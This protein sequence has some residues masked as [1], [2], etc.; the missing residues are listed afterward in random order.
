MANERKHSATEIIIS[1]YKSNNYQ[2]RQK[3]RTD[4]EYRKNQSCVYSKRSHD[5]MEAGRR[6][7][8]KGL[9]E[10]AP[11]FLLNH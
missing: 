4:S 11:P 7:S 3:M 1:E 9:R 10:K 5:F 2:G 6:S 8:V